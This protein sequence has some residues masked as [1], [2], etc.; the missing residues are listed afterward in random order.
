MRGALVSTIYGHGNILSEFGTAMALAM[1]RIDSFDELFIFTPISEANVSRFKPST[2]VI[3]KINTSKAS[4]YLEL[5]HSLR[6]GNFDVIVINSMPTSQGSSLI[7]NFLYIL[8]PLFLPNQIR[9]KVRIV[10]HNSPFLNDIAKLGYRGI[11]SLLQTYILK[12][13]EKKIFRNIRTFFLLETYAKKIRDQI[14]DA[15]VDSIQGKNIAVFSALYLNGKLDSPL[16]E[17]DPPQSGVPVVLLYGFW[18]PQKDLRT[19]LKAI[20]SLRDGPNSFT[21]YL[22]GGTNV[23]FKKNVE[24]Y[25]NILEEFSGTLDTVTGYV[26]EDQTT[27]LFLKSNII[28]LPYRAVGGFSGVLSHAMFY[29]LTII[30]PKY[31]E[32]VE[33]CGDYPIVHF[34]PVEY[35]WQD[36]AMALNSILNAGVYGRKEISPFSEFQDFVRDFERK[37]I[38]CESKQG[39]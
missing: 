26:E 27:D 20:Q 35:V 36:I 5:Y 8:I 34:I 28:I 25:E 7:S 16:L 3:Q 4:S 23:H 14:P 11:K 10:Y 38:N 12:L 30:V 29:G 21:T 18:G 24:W 6:K 37:V 9:K 1:E 39:V 31:K 13:L 19:A 33:Q 17:A 15:K 32:Y 22:A 2:K